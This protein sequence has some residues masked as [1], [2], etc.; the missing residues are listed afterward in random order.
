VLIGVGC[1]AGAFVVAW[2]LDRGVRSHLVL[3]GFLMGLVA[4]LLYVGMVAGAGQMSTALAAYGPATFVIVNGARLLGA[5]M[6]GL[7]CERTR[8]VR[9]G[10]GAAI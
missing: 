2:W 8:V 1:F 7:A 6:G 9:A 5:V 10:G 4:T 3:H